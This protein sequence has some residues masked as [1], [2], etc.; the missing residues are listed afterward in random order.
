MLT[1]AAKELDARV[2][3]LNQDAKADLVPLALAIA[4]RVVRLSADRDPKA[5]EGNVQ[6]AVR[7]VISKHSIRIAVHP[8]QKTAIDALLPQLKLQWPTLQ[9]VEVNEDAT[10]STG[11]CKIY[12][13]GGMIDATLE[14]QIDRIA[15]ELACGPG[16]EVNGAKED[17]KTPPQPPTGNTPK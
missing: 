8:S 13:A 7:L 15:N 4:R 9:S 3:S 11:G 2:Q 12:S 16:V 17:I 5:V 14:T 10:V 6:E 1:K